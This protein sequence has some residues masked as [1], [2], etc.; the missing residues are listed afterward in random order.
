MMLVHKSKLVLLGGIVFV[1]A[2]LYIWFN[3][4]DWFGMQY[5]FAAMFLFCGVVLIFMYQPKQYEKEFGFLD[6]VEV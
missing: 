2:S 4:K 3:F 6:K 1:L 5:I